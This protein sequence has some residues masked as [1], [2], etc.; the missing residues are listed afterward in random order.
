M[1]QPDV[2]FPSFE[3]WLKINYPNLK[4]HQFAEAREKYIALLKE[5]E[6]Q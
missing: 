5:W 3:T 4:R 1:S 2:F 6:A